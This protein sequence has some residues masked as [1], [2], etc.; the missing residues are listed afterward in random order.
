MFLWKI[1]IGIDSGIAYVVSVEKQVEISDV[2]GL[3]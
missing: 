3:T 1:G 2:E